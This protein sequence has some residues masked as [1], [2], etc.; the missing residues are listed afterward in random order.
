VAVVTVDTGAVELQAA[1]VT[2]YVK[3][4]HD[5]HVGMKITRNKK[6]L[7]GW[8]LCNS[9]LVQWIRE[10]S[11]LH[12]Y[13]CAVSQIPRHLPGRFLSLQYLAVLN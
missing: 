9:L 8:A 5:P 1:T 4:A 12:V 3:A 6:V 11:L 2:C 10:E 7:H 13:A